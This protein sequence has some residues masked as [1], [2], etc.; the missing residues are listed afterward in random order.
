MMSP[1]WLFPSLLSIFNSYMDL[2]EVFS[3]AIFLRVR[4]MSSNL[5]GMSHYLLKYFPVIFIGPLFDRVYSFFFT[6]SM[7]RLVLT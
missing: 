5:L 6:S 3:Y 4:F 7:L 2:L 1:V